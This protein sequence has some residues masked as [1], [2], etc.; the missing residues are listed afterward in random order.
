MFQ[1][2]DLKYQLLHLF[3]WM[4]PN[5]KFL[6]KSLNL[7]TQYNGADIFT[8]NKDQGNTAVSA[9]EK[10]VYSYTASVP[11]FT[12]AGTWDIYLKL[13]DSNDKV[14]SSLKCQFVME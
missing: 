6:N 4:K 5:F 12:P 9:G 13:Q 8:D 14:I 2:M 1:S 3:A 7:V 10:Y 11:T